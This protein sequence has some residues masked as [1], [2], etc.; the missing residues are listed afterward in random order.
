MRGAFF[1]AFS[2]FSVF[3]RFSAPGVAP[4]RW[5]E[6]PPR[7][8]GGALGSIPNFAAIWGTCIDTLVTAAISSSLGDAGIETGSTLVCTGES[9]SASST[10]LQRL[11]P[12]WSVRAAPAAVPG[13]RRGRSAAVC[14]PWV[15]GS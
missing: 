10:V 3:S 13:A 2:A 14:P 5:R 11:G 15:G 7:V 9:A 12:I 8:R 4:P 1:S 6:R